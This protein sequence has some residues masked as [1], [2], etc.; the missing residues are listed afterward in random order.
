M[1]LLSAHTCLRL[2]WL[3]SALLLTASSILPHSQHDKQV[4]HDSDKKQNYAL[5]QM[6]DSDQVVVHLAYTLSY[7]EKHEQAKWVAYILT[8]EQV[9]ERVAERGNNFREDPDVKTG[10]ATLAD[11]KRSGYDRGH[12]APAADMAWSEEAMSESFY[13]S[14]MSPQTPSFNRGI[15]KYLEEL[16][17][18]WARLYDTLYIVTGPVL[19]ANLP[20]I[21]PNHVSIPTH[22]YK[23]IFRLT[24]NLPEGIAFLLPNLKTQQKN[25]LSSYVITIDS[26]ENLT[27]LNFFPA[28]PD[29]IENEMESHSCIPCWEW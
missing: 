9:T 24:D 17:R 20:T 26:L 11:Y 21:G 22:Y 6:D 12:L 7:S 2:L 8:C 4:W 15:W 16:I 28:L 19:T 1:G 10:S 13:L 29:S 14:N 18:D 3:F 27:H 5:P 25:P 23:A